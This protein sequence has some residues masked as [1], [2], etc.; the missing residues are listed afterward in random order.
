MG[1]VLS[2]FRNGYPG[3]VSRS[4]DDIIVSLR[5]ASGGPVP[6]GAPV[7]LVAGENAC[8]AFDAASATSDNFVG[9]AVRLP[10]K[11]PD[12]YGSNLGSYA[13]NEP[14]DV[15]VRGNVVMQFEGSASVGASVYIRKSDGKIVAAPGAEGTTLQLPGVTVRTPR[16]SGRCAEVTLTRRNL[17]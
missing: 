15:L 3:A 6:F 2:T 8:R 13:A 11:T 9:I 17:I 7:F 14:V 16:D 5:N 1:K 10:D 4:N 12:T